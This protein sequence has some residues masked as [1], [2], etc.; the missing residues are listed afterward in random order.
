MTP[1]PANYHHCHHRHAPRRTTHIAW[2]HGT[3]VTTGTIISETRRCSACGAIWLIPVV[4]DAAR[5]SE[6]Q[7]W[8]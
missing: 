8:S 4:E 7:R 5:M 3:G 2:T 6:A 1:T